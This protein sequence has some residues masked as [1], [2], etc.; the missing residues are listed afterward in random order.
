[1]RT[2]GMSS[3]LTPSKL[4]TRSQTTAGGAGTTEETVNDVGRGTRA[5]P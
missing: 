4:A 1:M 3:S 5:A 2:I